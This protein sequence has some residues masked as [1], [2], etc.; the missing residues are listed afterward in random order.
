MDEKKI[1]IKN[2][3]LKQG[4]IIS[5]NKGSGN[6]IRYRI[7]YINHEFASCC[8]MD[9]SKCE[10]FEMSTIFLMNL[11]MTNQIRIDD[12]STLP[13]IDFNEVSD[14]EKNKFQRIKECCRKLDE[15]FGPT[16]LT[17][18][19]AHQRDIIND[20]IRQSEY[21]RSTYW[22]IVRKYLQSGFDTIALL[23]GRIL[24]NNH[25]KERKLTKKTGKG[26][27][28]GLLL[29]EDLKKKFQIGLDNYCSGRSYTMKAAFADILNLFF[30]TSSSING[31]IESTWLPESELPTYRQFS[32]YVRRNLSKEKFDVIKT[33]RREQRNDKRITPSDTLQGVEHPGDLF[34]VDEQ[35]FD[36]SS[37]S[38]LDKSKVIGRFIVYCMIDVYSKMIVSIHVSL[39]NNSF[40]GITSCL[41]NL[42]DDKV[43]L[44]KQVGIDI[45]EKM[46]PISKIIPNRLR[47]DR[48]A[49][50]LSNK[51]GRTCA[52]LNIDIQNVP[53]ATG[54]M[55]GNVEQYFNSVNV[56]IKPYLEGN[57][58][59]TKRYDSNHHQTACLDINQ[60]TK[61]AYTCALYHNHHYIKSY[62]LTQDMLDHGVDRKPIEIWN[63]GCKWVDGPKHISN[64][65]QFLYS[66]LLPV[67]ASISKN[68]IKYKHL[69]YF[70][71][72]NKQLKIEMYES[73]S[74]Q[75][76]INARIDP[77]DLSFIY[78]LENNYLTKIPLSEIKTSNEP[79]LHRR[80]SEDEYA[81]YY[82]R[83]LHENREGERYN[84][85]LAATRNGLIK[86]I[87]SSE[88]TKSANNI[89]GINEN[90]D[91][92][93]VFLNTKNRIAERLEIKNES[94][95]EA[96][97][98]NKVNLSIDSYESLEEANERFLEDN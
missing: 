87:I 32:Y 84:E 11:L 61:I 70:D 45:E 20:L 2:Y 37:V 21:A 79:F 93:K 78:R 98:I 33:S 41:L 81:Q 46:W 36:V 59:I 6:N 25:G 19:S 68:G 1:E 10:V 62:P 13:T 43:E 29:D 23:D 58:L 35:E 39:E 74:K 64:K 27:Q 50:Y 65:D 94:V 28:Y 49:E 86:E 82:K 66:C 31:V 83:Q 88:S 91:E 77:R 95:E 69:I 55:K 15:I 8:Q 57:G 48:G 80:I 73:G 26:N 75:T 67:K 4:D 76:K 53:A 44:C 24:Q 47:S 3:Q 96:L 5:D 16:Y 7:L 71:K 9:T 60:I 14:D 97:D 92:E 12:S 72:N 90:R 51:F 22:R 56:A 38:A 54:S 89:R 42:W 17:L 85:R 34:E 40:I 18:K 63:Y 30:S 52:E